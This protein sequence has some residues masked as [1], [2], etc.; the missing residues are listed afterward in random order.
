MALLSR[1]S[2]KGLTI[3]SSHAKG[4]AWAMA[5]PPSWTVKEPVD[6]LQVIVKSLGGGWPSHLIC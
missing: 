5:N 6:P 3:A 4:M 2:H 1:P